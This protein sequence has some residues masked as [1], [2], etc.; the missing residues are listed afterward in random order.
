MS[1]RQPGRP[2]VAVVGRPNVGKSA[3]FNRLLS[4]RLAIVEE[5]PGVTRDRLQAPCDWGGRAFTLVDTGGLVPGGGGEPL[6]HQVRRQAEQAI[7]EAD[8]ILFVVDAPAGLVPQDEEIAGLLRESRRP[9]LLVA[10]KVDSAPRALDVYEFHALGLGEPIAVSALHGLGVGDLLDAIVAVLPEAGAE[11]PDGAGPAGEAVRIAFLGRPNVGKSSLVNALL[12]EERV[13]VDARPGT[14][15][16]AIDTALTYDG[17]AVVLIDTAGL[18]RRSRVDEKVEFYSTRRTY[19]ALTR[20]DVAVLV[21][22]AV[23]GITDQDQRIARTVY[24]AG[25]GM[26]VAVNKWDLLEGHTPEQVRR[27]AQDRFRFFGTV[28]VVLTSAVRPEGIAELMQGALRAARARR[29]R[30]PTGPLNR[31]VEQ[32]VQASH[33]AA[34][35]S[36][37]RLHIYYVTQPQAN[38]PT[39]VLFVNDPRL[40]SEDYRR[41]LERRVREAFDLAGTPVRWALRGRRARAAT[42]TIGEAEGDA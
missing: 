31:L 23:E 32:A 37:R 34:D 20:A 38:P 27:V 26:V 30:I 29:T 15:R 9:V 40:L 41:Y 42:R 7:A 36:G 13:I 28:L 33:P 39:F 10:N 24:D 17:R 8:V 11:T 22:D 1:L 21:V 5:T 12:G 18:R 25:R 19:E 14:T 4:R 2:T 6:A 35:P 16:D 3:L